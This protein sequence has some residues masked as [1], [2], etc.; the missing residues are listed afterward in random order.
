[1]IS[2]ELRDFVREIHKDRFKEL[3]NNIVKELKNDRPRIWRALKKISD[4]LF[5]QGINWSHI[6]TFM[7]FC[8]ELRCRALEHFNKD[9]GDKFTRLLIDWICR[10][11]EENLMQWINE[12]E[13]GWLD[14]TT[15]LSGREHSQKRI[16]ISVATLAVF[17]GVL[18]TTIS[19]LLHR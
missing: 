5:S 4:E 6:V 8:A 19:S 15:T 7:V 18:Y 13:G 14:V 10:Y 17:V 3:T 16:V 1:M 11:F 9:E 2:N 12:Q